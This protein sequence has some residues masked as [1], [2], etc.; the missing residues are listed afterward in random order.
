MKATQPVLTSRSSNMTSWTFLALRR[1]DMNIDPVQGE[2]FAEQDIADRLV[3]EAL[4][5][6]LDAR[7]DRDVVGPVEVEF[8]IKRDQS[9]AP[10]RVEK[11]FRGLEPHLEASLDSHA[12]GRAL[13]GQLGGQ[14][15]VPYLLI[16]DFNTTGLIGDIEQ[17]HNLQ[18]V[19]DPPNDF[20][21]FV[22]NV[23]RSGKRGVEGGSWGLGKWVF[24]DASKVNSYFF[25]TNRAD[26][27]RT[28][29]MGQSVLKSH[30]LTVN[31]Q[32]TS[33]LPYGYYAEIDPVDGFQMPIQASPRLQEVTEDFQLGRSNLSG[34]SLIIPFP[35]EDLGH[36][37]LLSAVIRY[38]FY[39]ILCQDLKVSVSEDSRSTVV[40]LET[41]FDV[42]EGIDL[43]P[44]A[45]P[46]SEMRDMFELAQSYR[47]LPD[48]ERIELGSSDRRRAPASIRERM[49]DDTL[50]SARYRFEQGD[51]LVFRIPV[52]IHAA[53]GPT[54]ASYFDLAVQRMIGTGSSHTVHV[55]NN[56][57]I[58]RAGANVGNS[59]PVRA[60][61][62][63][64]D[65]PLARLMRDSEG[66]AH[67]RWSE[68]A[69]KV[70]ED[71]IR[72]PS[73]V[74]FVNG[75]VRDLIRCLT[76]S[77]D[78]I[79]RNL[80]LDY[81]RK[82]QPNIVNPTP[83]R[84]P[85]PHT[86]PIRV[87][88]IPGGFTVRMREDGQQDSE[89]YRI[90]VAYVVRRGNPLRRYDPRDFRLDSGPISIESN[91]AAFEVVEPNQMIVEPTGTS[92]TMTVEGFDR[93]RDLFVR[94]DRET[95]QT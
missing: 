54:E 49:D 15:P 81:F 33:H 58:P 91:N 80:L 19:D 65:H 89:A 51:L 60:L 74:R 44:S 45:I 95:E 61:L 35:E 63:V 30:P 76:S 68:R 40:D 46:P 83:P 71:Y 34:L 32:A 11:Y 5:N 75:A 4:Q 66:P 77:P 14:V 73:T 47:T 37:T 41:I 31:G 1:A 23:G 94:V 8:S 67:S 7:L 69:Q 56:L 27:N 16:E 3:R 39:P 64:Q 48:L 24:P 18:D 88:R 26:D 38:Y 42:L 86:P 13:L 78:G 21:Y 79:Y 90:K 50:A 12:P 10:S 20:Y 25:C 53:S 43:G 72:G 22:R 28:M 87:T 52:W 84:P 29:F 62:N 6:S 93:N 82:P 2:F 85:S 36:D 70:R 92:P 59:P 57:T 9:L 55:R 17:E